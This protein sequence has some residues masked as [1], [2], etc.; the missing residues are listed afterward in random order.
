[1]AA[2]LGAAGAGPGVGPVGS[3]GLTAGAAVC[4]AVGGSCGPGWLNANVIE[5]HEEASMVVAR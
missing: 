5:S 4:A 2:G 1:V 3:T